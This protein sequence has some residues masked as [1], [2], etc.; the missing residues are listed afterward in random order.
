MKYQRAT[1]EIPFNYIGEGFLDIFLKSNLC[2]PRDHKHS[3]EDTS[4]KTKVTDEVLEI[5]S[6]ILSHSDLLDIVPKR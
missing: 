6:C 2:L 3:H 4:V 1:L 5:Y